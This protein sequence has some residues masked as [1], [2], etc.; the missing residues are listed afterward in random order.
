MASI[1]VLIADDHAG[2]RRGLRQILELADGIQV[3]AEAETGPQALELAARVA[4]DVALV[5]LSMPGMGGIDLIGQLRERRADLPIIVFSMHSEAQIVQRAL[6]AGARGYLVKGCDAE[7]VVEA[8]VAAAEGRPC[9]VPGGTFP[10]LARL[11]PPRREL[12]SV[13]GQRVLAMLEQGQSADMIA[14]HLNMRLGTISSYIDR[15]RGMAAACAPEIDG[16]SK[17]QQAGGGE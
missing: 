2:V 11:P 12:L 9:P 6:G 15:I 17:P 10:R 16:P 3:A 4:V 13:V 1:R 7:Q 14:T 8:V 5:D